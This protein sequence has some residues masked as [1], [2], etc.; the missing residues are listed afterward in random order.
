[1]FVACVV[2]IHKHLAAEDGA[3]H[4]AEIH[5]SGDIFHID[6]NVLRQA[7]A[8]LLQGA[9]ENRQKWCAGVLN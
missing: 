5:G 7:L 9:L 1:M 4:F 8:Y 2:Q 3:G 6:A